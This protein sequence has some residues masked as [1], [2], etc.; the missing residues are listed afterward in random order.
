MRLHPAALPITVAAL[1]AAGCSGTAAAEV[2][3]ELDGRTFVSVAVAGEQIPGGAPLTVTFAGGQIRTFAGC[4][5]GSGP[6]DLG[7]GRVVTQ[8]ATTMMAC[9]PPVGDADAWVDRL[10]QAQPS[11][12]LSGDTLTLH[13]P[14]TTVTLRDR[15]VVDPDRPLIGTSWRVDTLITG[16]A[17]MTSVA[18]EQSKPGLTF[19]PDRTVTGW[20]GCNTFYGRVD[21]TGDTATFGPL[22]RS[23]PACAGEVGDIER[24]I[25]RVLTGSVTA[26]VD[27]DRLTL[28]G[29]EGNGLVLRAE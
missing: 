21:V 24:S 6:V 16:Q 3:D 20:T 22:N 17:A 28:T 29:A 2:G 11:W 5:H 8:L 7:D 10:F 14:A 12:A 9:P 26:S 25:L 27:A 15:S 4:N 23:G 18:L 19:R 13:G 1:A